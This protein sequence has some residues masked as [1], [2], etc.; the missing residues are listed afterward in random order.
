MHVAVE[1]DQ[2]HGLSDG[3]LVLRLKLGNAEALNVLLNR[4]SEA[5]YRF[6]S[7]IASSREDAEDVCQEAMAR[8]I[9]R[10]DSLQTGGAFR[11]WLFSIARNLA[12]DSYR[13]RRRI[14]PLTEEE[15]GVLPRAEESPEE[16]VEVREEQQTVAE[17][18]GKLAQSHQ[19]V[20]VLR[21]V[22]GLSYHEIADEL[23]VSQSAVE[24]LLFRARRRLREEYSKS[25]ALPG[26]LVLG[27]LRSLAERMAPIAG[28]PLLKGGL[29]TAAILGGVVATPR[30]AA[31]LQR[32][33]QPA[34]PLVRSQSGAGG[35]RE[36]TMQL[37]QAANIHPESARSVAAADV[38]SPPSHITANSALP[39]HRGSLAG[40]LGAHHRTSL[41]RLPPGSR[42][43]VASRAASPPAPAAAAASASVSTAVIRSRPS[44]TVGNGRAA[45]T[46]RA[47]RGAGGTNRAHPRGSSLKSAFRQAARLQAPSAGSQ[48]RTLAPNSQ[49]QVGSTRSRHVNARRSPQAARPLVASS[50]AA[51]SSKLKVHSRVST[52]NVPAGGSD[53]KGQARNPGSGSGNPGVATP[54]G[55]PTTAATTVVA[56]GQLKKPSRP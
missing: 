12:M 54:S 45:L 49:S 44:R 19:R 39:H 42:P 33:V 23:D 36:R 32:S 38:A 55:K 28:V 53:A 4:H 50:R 30:V 14:C 9:T 51:V 27:A 41:R 22:E 34:V 3:E 56:L 8:A 52:A 46:L 13:S 24:T 25:A 21:E 31:T 1:R 7:H 35:R 43:A 20:L 2:L 11:G 18:L 10:V 40:R 29:V 17:A 15:Q 6:C 37:T 47:G 16:R 48:A 26:A 5:L